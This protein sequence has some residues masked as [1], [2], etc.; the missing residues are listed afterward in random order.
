MPYTPNTWATGDTITADKLNHMEDGISEASSYDAVILLTHAD[1]TAYDTS[2]QII[3]SIVSGTFE[4]CA[5]KILNGEPP[6]ILIRYKHEL[7]ATYMWES[8]IAVI[9][10]CTST[11]FNI[12]IY[13]PFRVGSS[14]INAFS[15]MLHWTS[16]DTISWD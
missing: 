11:W 4:A 10:Y 8:S 6:K 3:P 16:S 14:G 5:S 7:F 9:D 12:L 1:N 2:D 15:D 13:G